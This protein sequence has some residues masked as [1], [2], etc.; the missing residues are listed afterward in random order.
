MIL[1][2]YNLHSGRSHPFFVCH[3]NLRQTLYKQLSF[4]AELTL[5]QRRIHR[6]RLLL[7][8]HRNPFILLI[9]LILVTLIN[10]LFFWPARSVFSGGIFFLARWFLFVFQPD[11]FI[12]FWPDN[13]DILFYIIFAFVVLLL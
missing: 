6:V 8:L 11:V 7:Q 13:K 12:I 3:L 2:E 9:S 5:L 1:M 4:L 10:L